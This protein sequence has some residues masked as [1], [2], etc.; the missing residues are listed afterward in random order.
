[1]KF[2]LKI[3]KG[4]VQEFTDAGGIVYKPG[5]VVD[6]PSSY[7]GEVWLERMDPVPVV[8]APPCKFEPA[9]VVDALAAVVVE[10]ALVPFA[11]KPKRQRT[12]KIPRLFR[13]K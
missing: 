3:G 8:A 2:R 6:L 7:E 11:A 12:Q 5:E 13:R 4:S 10:P 1:L 9:A